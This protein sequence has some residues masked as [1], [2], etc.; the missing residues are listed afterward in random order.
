MSL[1]L[2]KFDQPRGFDAMRAETAD[3]TRI[4]SH[5]RVSVQPGDRVVIFN[6]PEK[7][8]AAV[9]TV[10]EPACPRSEGEELERWPYAFGTRP[11]TLSA[12][13]PKR[14]VPGR[15]FRRLGDKE[16]AELEAVVRLN[17]L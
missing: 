16:F 17:R 1:W 12:R 10:T 8:V 11:E 4:A 5:V 13:G 7:H 6:I 9:V 3:F 14:S 2:F 15:N